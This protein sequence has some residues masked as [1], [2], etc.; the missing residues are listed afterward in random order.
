MAWY[1]ASINGRNFLLDFDG[2][3]ARY[4]FYQAVLVQGADLAEAETNAIGF[5]KSDE[6]LQQ[7]VKNERT[8]P[9]MLFLDSYQE[10]DQSEL[11]PPPKG[12]TYY[13]EKSWWQFWR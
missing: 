8:D 1:L 9:P 13:P 6:E 2:K 11:P 3:I 10:L 7:L 4:G 12:R 5:V